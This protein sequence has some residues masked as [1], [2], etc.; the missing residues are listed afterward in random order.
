[1]KKYKVYI[2]TET[3]YY[4]NRLLGVVKALNRKQARHKALAQYQ[5]K[6]FEFCHVYGH[7]TN[8]YCLEA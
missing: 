2:E 5:S 3:G 7:E 4:Q 8:I 6:F 1:M